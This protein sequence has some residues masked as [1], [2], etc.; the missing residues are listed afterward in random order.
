MTRAA[1][2]VTALL[3]AALAAALL[4]LA[5]LASPATAADETESHGDEATGF[6]SGQWDGMLLAAGAGLVMGLV[7]FSMSDPGGIPRVGHGDGH[8]HH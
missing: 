8:G 6:G 4:S 7:A 3:L 5:L 2:R 1:G